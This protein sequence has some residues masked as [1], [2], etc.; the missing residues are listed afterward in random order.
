MFLHSLL[1]IWQENQVGFIT[2]TLKIYQHLGGRSEFIGDSSSLEK[3]AVHYLQK[4]LT[5][6]LTNIKL[7][8]KDS[9]IR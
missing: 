1:K 3:A 6:A 2:N 4:A 7:D 9:Q 5:P 8:W